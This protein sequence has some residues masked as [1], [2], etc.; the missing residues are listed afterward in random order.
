MD[1]KRT[2]YLFTLLAILIFSLQDAI[3]KHLGSLY[4]P[5]FIAMLR[6]WA[7]GAF[8]MALG[9][10]S[11]GGLKVVAATKRPALQILRGVL[12]AFQIVV[13][14]T[15]FT[16]VGLAHS[17]AILASGPIFVALLSMPLLGE[18]VGW[19][20]WTAIGIGLCGVLII[21][22]PAG[23]A[24]DMGVL[25][26]LISALMFAVYVIATR[27]VS[28]EDTASTSFFYTGVV[29]AVAISLVGPFFWTNLT[30]GDW[31]W[32][33]LLCITGM[34]SHYFLIRAYDLLDAAAVQ[35]LTYLQVVLAAIIGVSVFGE[36]LNLN[37][38]L[39]S[40]IVVGAGIFTIW[41]ESVVARR[42]AAEN[43]IGKNTGK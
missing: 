33:G 8:A 5:V 25:L 36:T 27:L 26:P 18:R 28:R 16:K 29:G 10:R 32:M 17:Q 38:V 7:F 24:F 13:T 3:S 12:L 39:G 37:M 21:L 14:I 34:S 42:R 43:R 35:P 15:A 2:G 20:R 40:A 30:P 19:R 31:L 6:F 41:R 11:P 1:S 23:S 9:A 4:P 22:N